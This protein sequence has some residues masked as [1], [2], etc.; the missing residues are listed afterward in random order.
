MASLAELRKRTEA[1][2]EQP[3]PPRTRG[4]TRGAAAAVAAPRAFSLFVPEQLKEAID[5]AAELMELANATEGEEGLQ[6][7]LDAVEATVRDRDIELVKYALMVFV[8]HHPKG[9]LL[10]IPSLDRRAPEAIL[11]SRTTATRA[12]LGLEAQLDWFREDTWV[13]DHHSKWH[14]VYP[15]EGHPNPQSP[16]QRVLRSR[17]GELFYYMHQQMLARY[18]SER[19]ALGL[20][21]TQPLS[22]YGVPVPEG[23][24][25]NLPGFSNRPPNVT[26]HDITF[27]NGALYRVQDHM[28]RRD[29]LMNAATAGTLVRGGANVP[30]ADIS[31]IAA[32]A[33]STMG[34]ADGAGW[35][36]ALSFYGSYHN[37][38]HVLL[39]DL[40]DAA[41]PNA[42]EPGVMTSTA[43]AMRDPI[44]YRWHRHVDDVF[45]TWQE[46]HLQPYNF[47][48][49]PAGIVLR[50]SLAGWPPG[51]SPDVIVCQLRDVPGGNAPGFDGRAFAQQTFG[52]GAW[53]LPRASLPTV[54]GRL[55]T[56]MRVET[57]ALPNGATVGKPYLDHEDFF[58]CFRVEN[59]SSQNRPVTVRVFLAAAAFADQRRLWIEMDKFGITLPASQRSVIYRPSRLASVV[60]KPAW[61]PT[62][63]RSVPAPGTPD[64]AR[65]YCD[66]GWPYHLL[67]PRGT[68]AGMPFRL[69]VMMTDWTVD[70]VGADSACGSLSFCGARDADYPDARAMGYPFDRP[71][72]GGL[73]VSGMLAHPSL[74]HVAATTVTIRLV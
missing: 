73:T 4:A 19:A 32:T 38:G 7:V 33:E 39:A 5:L 63:P 71:M 23:Y 58:F 6:R 8:T 17:Q 52:G 54:T 67:L 40:A 65:S 9:R 3:P 11:P 20:P 68:A 41:G 16:Q 74:R 18:D 47:A 21:A 46:R 48:D 66:C 55:D 42:S 64:E 14:I 28:Q 59:Q 72:A 53:D 69:M 57:I 60:R 31:Q 26:P 50:K 1:F 24:I 13:N 25:A 51:E 15:G 56:H 43:T 34:S 70:R 61:R 2:L 10:P 22:N 45:F 35:L 27:P 44:F 37:F 49:A 62:E 36:N 29:R 30:I 12:A